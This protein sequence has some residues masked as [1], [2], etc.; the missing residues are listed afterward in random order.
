MFFEL[1][2]WQAKDKRPN[3]L[4]SHHLSLSHCSNIHNHW[5]LLLLLLLFWSYCLRFCLPSVITTI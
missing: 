2:W 4:P 1:I 5:L 3:L